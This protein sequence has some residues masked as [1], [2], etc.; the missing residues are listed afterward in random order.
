MKVWLNDETKQMQ[1][2]VTLQQALDAWKYTG[3]GFAV[4]INHEFVPK[5]NYGAIK[6]KAGDKI[7]IVT[8]MQGG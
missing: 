2:T 6:L 3:S 1:E 4:A 5:Q 8:P 7:D